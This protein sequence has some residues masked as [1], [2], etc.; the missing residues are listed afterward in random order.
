[1]PTRSN[2]SRVRLDAG[3]ALVD[4]VVR[5]GRAGVV[6]GRLL[7]LGQLVRR[8]ERRVAGQVAVVGRDR[9]LLVADRPV[10]AA[11][12]R[13]DLGQHRGEVEAVAAGVAG[14]LGPQLVA[15]E[16][17]PGEREGH[18]GRPGRRRARRRGR[19]PPSGPRSSSGR[20]TPAAP[21][22]N[23]PPPRR[24]P[25]LRRSPAGS[26]Q[27]DSLPRPPHPG[28]HHPAGRAR[29]CADAELCGGWGGDGIQS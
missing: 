21:P 20:S 22:P 1:M 26:A 19:G 7:R 17:V 28:T 13:R 4:G 2:V 15:D 18:R 14:G 25:T 12:D 29:R 3:Q 8:G 23:T 5:R 9:R 16:H 11:D 27:R 24:R 6:A 10:G